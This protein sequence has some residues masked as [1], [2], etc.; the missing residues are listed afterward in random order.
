MIRECNDDLILP[1]SAFRALS[2]TQPPADVFDRT[3][4][5]EERKE[6]SSQRGFKVCAD[7]R[8]GSDAV[9]AKD[10]CCMNSYRGS[11]FVRALGMWRKNITPCWIAVI[12]IAPVSAKGTSQDRSGR[13][14][15]NILRARYILQCRSFLRAGS[16]YY[17]A[18]ELE[19]IL[20]KRCVWTHL[21]C[22]YVSHQAL[23]VKRFP[24]SNKRVGLYEIT[25]RLRHIGAS[26][27]TPWFPDSPAENFRAES[28]VYRVIAT[29]PTN[30]S[31]GVSDDC[32]V[33]RTP[34][35]LHFNSSCGR[36][37]VLG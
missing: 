29:A 10:E 28:R 4:N 6:K 7:N 36:G 37:N 19:R 5:A 18:G 23:R 3:D 15:A 35:N 9:N 11:T 1:T 22:T 33:K 8:R 26:G 2:P 27:S 13:V 16:G 34:V 30:P 31:K 12:R 14:S 17:Y 32:L 21:S 25:M 20:F 24:S